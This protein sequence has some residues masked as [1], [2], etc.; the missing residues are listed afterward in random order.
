MKLAKQI[1]L[2]AE[3]FSLRGIISLTAILLLLFL[4]IKPGQACGKETSPYRFQR[5]IETP[6]LKQAELITVPLD[7][8]IYATTQVSLNDLRIQD[9]NGTSVPFLVRRKNKTESIE[10]QRIWTASGVSLNPIE[11][12]GLDIRFELD[13]DDPIP[14]GLR[15][16]TPLKNFEQRVTVFA[17]DEAGQ[18]LLLTEDEV[19]FDY[20]QFMDLRSVDI[21]LSGGD[22]RK[23]RIN[24]NSLTSRQ[25]TQL[26]ELTRQL[27]GG[28]E[29]SLLFRTAIIDRPFRIDRIELWSNY[30]EARTIAISDFPYELSSVETSIEDN[31]NATVIDV[32]SNSQPLTQFRIKTPE[33]NFQRKATLYEI[34]IQHGS[35]HLV[36][37]GAESLLHIDFRDIQQEQVEIRFPESRHGRYR[38]IIA[39]GDNQPLPIH[40]VQ[41]AGHID[42]IVFLANNGLRYVLQYGNPNLNKPDLDTAAIQTLINK[43]IEPIAASLSNEAT[44]L[45]D[46]LVPPTS[47]K[48]TLNNPFLL[49]SIAV[50]MIA[51]L[52]WLLYSAAKQVDHLP[53][54]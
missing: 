30:K 27:S 20:S 4:G 9:D 29:V 34:V 6:E 41:A 1:P 50:A 48:D 54:N 3:W 49:G 42:E 24:I 19:I 31:T 10:A 32:V 2:W 47:W 16:I 35:S 26:T 14:D 39:N 53:E 8:A 51:V 18:E 17:I 15:L 21:K 28:E 7:S 23:F 33:L 44:I 46:P 22:A 13:D 38:L 36:Q 11:G 37:I 40:D 43:G 12:T 5:L 25:Q 52:G 45:V